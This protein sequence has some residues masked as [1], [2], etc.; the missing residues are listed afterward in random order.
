MLV[1]NPHV[2]RLIHKEKLMIF[3]V[4][5][6][7]TSIRCSYFRYCC[8]ETLDGLHLTRWSNDSISFVKSIKF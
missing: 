8:Y 4:I 1:D 3:Y 5:N 2:G 7:L 6:L